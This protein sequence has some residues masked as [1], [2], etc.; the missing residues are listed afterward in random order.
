MKDISLTRH[1][2]HLV[3]ETKYYQEALESRFGK[4][5]IRSGH[6]YQLFAYLRNLSAESGGAVRVRGMLLYPAVDNPLDSRFEIHGH[7]VSIMTVDL[8]QDWNHI[9]GR[10]LSCLGIGIKATD[11]SKNVRS[12]NRPSAIEAYRPL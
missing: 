5:R 3:V 2:E 9:R 12:S 11:V 10:L 8:D 4:D 1:G 7:E 6:L